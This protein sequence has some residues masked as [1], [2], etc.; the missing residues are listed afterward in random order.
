MQVIA[1]AR[2]YDNVRVREEG[3][4]FDVA[5][6]TKGT[7]FKPVEDATSAKPAVKRTAKATTDGAGDIA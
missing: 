3:E 5:D 7:W 6:G 2:G 1:T 4:V